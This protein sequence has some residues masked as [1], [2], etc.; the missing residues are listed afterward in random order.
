MY[1]IA[2]EYANGVTMTFTQFDTEE[3]VDILKVYD[4]NNNQLI[5]ELSGS[6]IPEPISMASGQI[7]LV[8]QSDGAMNHGGFTVEYEADNVGIDEADAFKGLQ[9]YPNPATNRLNVTFTQN[10]ASAYSVKLISVTGEVV[11]TENNNKF[12]GTYVNTIDL[13]AYAKGVYFL[14]LSNEIGTV[15]EK[16]IVK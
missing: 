8:F 13:S 3:G 6:E 1:K 14:S 5:T 11:Y 9:I 15:N 16:V 10:V 2:P 7:F 12:E 4:A